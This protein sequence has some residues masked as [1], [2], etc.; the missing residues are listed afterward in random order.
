MN[1]PFCDG[2]KSL[3]QILLSH[4][5]SGVESQMR[6]RGRDCLARHWNWKTYFGS[7]RLKIRKPHLQTCCTS[8]G[9]AGSIHTTDYSKQR[10]PR[11]GGWPRN[12]HHRIVVH[13]K[14]VNLTPNWSSIT[15]KHPKFRKSTDLYSWDSW[16]VY[17]QARLLK[18]LHSSPVK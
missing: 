6:I 7:Q 2:K 18:P 17:L 11:Q 12:H 14:K 15:Q 5:T 16:A 9:L 1:L 8:V 10:N 4:S 3:L 13:L